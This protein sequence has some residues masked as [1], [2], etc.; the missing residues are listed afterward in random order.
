MSAE[1]AH[2]GYAQQIVFGS[3]R[4]SRL[5]QIL[6]AVGARRVML[7]TSMGRSV[8]SEGAEVK[9]ALDGALVSTFDSATQHV[10]APIV[11]FGV[12]QARRE[13]VDGIVSFGGGSVMD[14]G[15]A[16]AFYVEQEMGLDYATWADRPALAHVTIP[17]TYSGAEVTP[18]FS[19]TDPLTKQRSGAGSHTLAPLAVIYDPTLTT[20]TP[21]RL[22]AATGLTALGHCVEVAFSPTRTPEAEA[23][24]LAGIRRILS[25]LPLAVSYPN[26]IDLRASMQ[27]A[28]C[29]AARA[30]Q[31]ASLGVL[32]GL[33]SILSGLT[34]ADHGL[35][36]AVL[37][38]HTLRF[39][40]SEAPV[41]ANRV[42]VALGAPES[43]WAVIDHL[44]HRLQLPSKLEEAG[45]RKEA[46][47]AAIPIAVS[48]WNVRNN[49][50]R[51]SEQDARDL[52]YGAF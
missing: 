40:A 21:L 50:R 25:S 22:T 10:P 31:N 14:T 44:I 16:I 46:I 19:V 5:P 42:G 17:T 36:N 23:V 18:Y 49:P 20:S 2:T 6:Q 7:V 32:H 52:L 1:W 24:A 30:L 35:L 28:S 4:L 27:E 51:V 45:V 48:N 41:D 33:T 38:P 39:T 34:G 15:K 43:P 9:G 11:Q 3:G 47:D 8:S 37:L 12:E 13:G 29:L 26:D